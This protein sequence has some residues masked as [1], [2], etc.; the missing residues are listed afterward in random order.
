MV[1]NA[2]SRTLFQVYRGGQ[3]YYWRKTEYPVKTTELSQ[4]THVPFIYRLKLYALC[5]NGEVR[6][7]SID[8]D[9]LN[10]SALSGRF[11]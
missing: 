10:R 3:F 9:L 4:V 2:T 5:I 1:F 7:T 11:K 6:F 8:S